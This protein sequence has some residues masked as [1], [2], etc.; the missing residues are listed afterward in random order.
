MKTTLAQD[1]EHR[2][3]HSTRKH[4]ASFDEHNLR[5]YSK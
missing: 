3:S 1:K 2:S 4:R 5:D